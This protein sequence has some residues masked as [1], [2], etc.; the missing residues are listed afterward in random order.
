MRGVRVLLDY[1]QRR[2]VESGWYQPAE[3][4][5]DGFGVEGHGGSASVL[6]AAARPGSGWGK[7]G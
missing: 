1:A 3:A 2:M 6:A 5:C 4:L 7:P